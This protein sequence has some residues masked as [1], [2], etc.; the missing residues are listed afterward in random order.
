MC[1]QYN[2]ALDSTNNGIAYR[3]NTST[4]LSLAKGVSYYGTR[5]NSIHALILK[6]VD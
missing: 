2:L 6:L 4:V 3:D 5:S 1:V